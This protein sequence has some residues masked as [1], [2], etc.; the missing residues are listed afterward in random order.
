M[1]EWMHDQDLVKNLQ[2]NFQS[3]TLADCENFIR[4]SWEDTNNL[5]MA[6]AD[7]DDVYMGTVSLKNIDRIAKNAEFAIAFRRCALGTGI[8]AFAM[9]EILRYGLEELGLAQ[10]YWYVS[11]KN[12]RAVRFYDKCGYPRVAPETLSLPASS[13]VG[14]MPNMLYYAVTA[15]QFSE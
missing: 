6:A 3:S 13:P 1:L 8:S 2:A 9:K 15:A 4:R 5:H 7:D 14:T 10:I 11:S 12:A